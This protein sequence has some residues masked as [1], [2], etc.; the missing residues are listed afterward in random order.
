MQLRQGFF[1]LLLHPQP[2]QVAFVGLATGVTASAALDRPEV[3]QITVMELIPEVV[4]AARLF[5]EENL[6]LLDDDR[7]QV[8]IGDG[9]NVLGSA[10]DRYD[11]IVSDLFVPWESKTGYLY[12]VEHF[13]AVQERLA[14]G[15]LFCQW[16]AGWQVGSKEFEIIVQSLRE[17][18]PHVSIWYLSRTDRHPLFALVAV[19]DHRHLSRA[20]L[21]AR[22]QQH[23]PPSLGSEDV[24]ESADDVVAGYLG[25]WEPLP[26]VSLNT[27]EHPIVE[28]SAPMTNRRRGKQLRAGTF[29]AYYKKRLNPLPRKVFTFDPPA[30]AE[31]RAVPD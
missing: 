2:K 5:D 14:D 1:P 8:R 22:L 7:V 12:T 31:E 20:S 11:V 6:G 17:V 16:L 27:D 25:D 29:H 9:R 19:E 30:R 23:R 13:E 24:V 15:G 3:E 4:E 28:F 10:T 21:Q 18:F 26:D